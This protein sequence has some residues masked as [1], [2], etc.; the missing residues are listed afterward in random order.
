[1]QLKPQFAMSACQTTASGFS[2]LAGQKRVPEENPIH[3]RN[4]SFEGMRSTLT[5]NLPF[6]KPEV[7]IIGS[8]MGLLKMCLCVRGAQALKCN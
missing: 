1:M 4:S 3:R 6:Y 2:D 5:S 7:L 8:Q